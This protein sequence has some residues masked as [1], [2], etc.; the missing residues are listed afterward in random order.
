MLLGKGV[1]ALLHGV[2]HF[3]QRRREWNQSVRLLVIIHRPPSMMALT[4][5]MRFLA[6]LMHSWRASSS[7]GSSG[8][9]SLRVPVPPSMNRNRAIALR[10][11]IRCQP[12]KIGLKLLVLQI[13]IQARAFLHI[14]RA[15]FIPLLL[16]HQLQRVEHDS[17]HFWGP[18]YDRPPLRLI[19]PG[20]LSRHERHGGRISLCGVGISP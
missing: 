7:L 16:A 10:A 1:T 12:T 2:F 3:A 11:K 17:S 9:I 4:Q 13:K 8:S 18:W 15:L 20:F 5:S 19:K 6:S 14:D